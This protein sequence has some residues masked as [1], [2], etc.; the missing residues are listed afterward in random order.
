M[1]TDVQVLTMG[2]LTNKTAPGYRLRVE[3]LNQAMEEIGVD[4]KITDLQTGPLRSIELLSFLSKR[5]RS[6]LKDILSKPGGKIVFYGLQPAVLLCL[7]RPSKVKQFEITVDVC[8][9]WLRLS[10]IGTKRGSIKIRLKLSL[11]GITYRTLEKRVNRFSYISNSDL[12]NDSGFLIAKDKSEVVP[13]G[14]PDWCVGTFFNAPGNSRQ[15][16]FVG[17][18]TYP[19]NQEAL[20]NAIELLGESFA[21]NALRLRVVGEGWHPIENEFI[22][23]I[24]WVEDLASEYESA[25]AT[26]ALMDSGAGV[27]NKVIESLAVGRAVLAS[28]Q[29]YSQ[30]KHIPGIHLANKS[31]LGN[32]LEKLANSTLETPS[33]NWVF[34]SWAESAQKVVEL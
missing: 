7:F 32:L 21:A 3:G 6:K 20:R 28:D 30:F 9:S 2:T 18:G 26:V 1:P 34:P 15:L 22:D 29:I 16:L 23:Y 8:D 25:G 27:S 14:I 17:S 19:P 5:N 4:L 24:G 10:E 33:K 12:L 31:T 11:V 13:N